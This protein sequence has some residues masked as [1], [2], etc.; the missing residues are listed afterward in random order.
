M[1]D[2]DDLARALIRLA[3]YDRKQARRRVR[4]RRLRKAGLIAITPLAGPLAGSLW[5]EQE[6]KGW[7]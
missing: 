7:R 3:E 2:A 6:R 5:H 4:S 1:G